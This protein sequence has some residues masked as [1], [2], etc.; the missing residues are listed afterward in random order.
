MFEAIT[1]N[2]FFKIALV[3]TVIFCIATLFSA[4]AEG[5]ALRAEQNRLEKLIDEYN[6]EILSLENDLSAPIDEDYIIRIA[7]RK[8]NMRLPEEIVFVTNITG[9]K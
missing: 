4:N 6:E 8:R 3:L 5:E 1:E 2:I 7:R 9:Q